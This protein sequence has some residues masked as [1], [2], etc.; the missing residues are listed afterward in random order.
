M[1]HEV[2]APRIDVRGWKRKPRR[3]TRYAKKSGVRSFRLVAARQSY[4]VR[5]SVSQRDAGSRGSYMSRIARTSPPGANFGNRCFEARTP[6]VRGE[7]NVLYAQW[8]RSFYSWAN[9]FGRSG[10]PKLAETFAPFWRGG[11]ALMK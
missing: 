5:A 3:R 8:R 6:S 4:A 10:L 2:I 1:I 11:A 9:A 7:F